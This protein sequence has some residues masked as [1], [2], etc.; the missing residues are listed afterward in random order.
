MKHPF[1]TGFNG[2]K[3]PV[4]LL[5]SEKNATV[6]IVEELIADET[7]STSINPSNTSHHNTTVNNTRDTSSLADS[8]IVSKDH[9]TT[10]TANAMHNNTQP[11]NSTSSLPNESMEIV[12]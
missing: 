11:T 2:D 1:I 6:N 12:S 5:L 7:A 4:Q 8:P 10:T 9:T 3:R